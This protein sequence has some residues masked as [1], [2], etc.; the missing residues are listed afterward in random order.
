MCSNVGQPRDGSRDVRVQQWRWSAVVS[1]W[2]DSALTS[3]VVVVVVVGSCEV[4]VF[5]FVGRK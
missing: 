5:V 1:R 3:V 4:R 2:C